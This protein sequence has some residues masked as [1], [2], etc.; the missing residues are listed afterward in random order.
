MQGRVVAG[1]GGAH[2]Q[3]EHG[4]GHPLGVVG[5]VLHPHA[6]RHLGDHVR[7]A[8]QLPAD[9]LDETADA[10]IVAHRRVAIDDL[11]LG[12]G[13]V[14]RGG[15]LDDFAQPAPQLLAHLGAGVAHRSQHGARRRDH[16][17]GRPRV[18]GPNGDHRRLLRVHRARDDGLQGSDDVGG[19]DDRID[20]AMRIGSVGPKTGDGHAERVAGRHGRPAANGDAAHRLERPGVQGNGR[21]HAR[22]LG[23][24]A[25][26]EHPAAAAVL[27]RRLEHELDLPRHL[28]G[29]RGQD[30]G[31]A[32]QH[33]G[34]PVVPASVHAPRHLRSVGHPGLFGDRQGVDVGAQQQALTRL[35]RV[36]HGDHVR[37]GQR[38][39]DLQVGQAGKQLAD[40]SRGLMFLECQ[41]RVGVQF[42]AKLGHLRN[43]LRDPTV[44]VNGCHSRHCRARPTAR[45][46][47]R[48]PA[49]L[50]TRP[51]LPSAGS[52]RRAIRRPAAVYR[53]PPSRS[54]P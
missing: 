26:A 42:A 6:D 3:S 8:E 44:E 5:E 51:W 14:G 35:A 11:D 50:N 15:V 21:V 52:P 40:A 29:H 2:A 22:V 49:A 1:L 33:R 45:H 30:H 32:R 41:F 4:R 17:L 31:R 27:L 12:L 43:D 54:P 25:L 24:P 34:V 20:A 16:V 39:Q 46:G 37:A 10:Q 36:K 23:H 48:P 38:R 28:I 19:G 18:D 47:R 9:L 13:P 53:W 7:V